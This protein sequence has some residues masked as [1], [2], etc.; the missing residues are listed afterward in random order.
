K[1]VDDDNYCVRVQYNSKANQPDVMLERWTQPP[2]DTWETTDIW[3]DSPV[4]GYGTYRYG[5]WNDLSGN[6]VP[7]GNGDDPAIG[8]VN[9]LYAR[10]RNVGT[11]AATNVVVNWEITDPPG[12]GIAGANGWAAVGSA[13]SAAFPGLANIAAGSFVDVYVEWTPNFAVSPADLA[14]GTFSFHTCVRVK[15]N[16]VAGELVLGNQDGDGEQEN[17]SYFQAAP[18]AGG[19]V[20]DKFI[21]LR[22][23]SLVARKFFDLS[24][25]SNL[26]AAWVLEVNGGVT[27]VELMPGEVKDI[28]IFIKPQGP[29]V[30]GSKFGVDVQ[31][32]SF[33]SLPND[34]KPTDR[35]PEYKKLGGVHVEARVLT[36]VKVACNAKKDGSKVVV[37]GRLE[38][39][40][41]AKYYNKKKPLKVM[42]EGVTASG[43]FI[44]ASSA[45]VIVDSKGNFRGSFALNEKDPSAKAVC[46]FAGTTEL[47]SASSGLIPIK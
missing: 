46:L 15:L 18:A 4:N 3:V 33:R 34:K 43:K 39:K 14:A 32:A 25:K 7:V 16:A 27:G 42:I 6:A 12:V 9:R 31:A 1:K 38:V 35:H 5:M 29:A 44:P 47:A 24:Y 37:T 23:D 21:R 41:F 17:I 22:N 28:P 19:P 30:V 36:P 10:V 26:P 8:Q 2:G 45:V 13:N 20:Y 40:D 11:S